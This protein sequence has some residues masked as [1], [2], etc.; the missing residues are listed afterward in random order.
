M[1][2]PTFT[3]KTDL[4]DI[5]YAADVNDLQNEVAPTASASAN[6]R[7]STSYTSTGNVVLTD[8]SMPVQSINFSSNS[9]ITLPAISTANHPFYLV[10]RSTA[11]IVS[12]IFSGSTLS[13]INPGYM[14]TL[15]SD[16]TASWKINSVAA[17]TTTVAG[18]VELATDA[19][20]ITGTDTA[21]AIT[22]ANLRAVLATA[23]NGTVFNLKLS[24]TVSSN[25]LVV[26]LKTHAGTDPSAT[27]PGYV[28]ING[29]VRS[30]T[31]ATSFT[32]ADGT[33]WFGSGAAELGTLEIDYFAYLVW[34]SN[35]SVVAISAARISHG[36]TVNATDF[37]TTTT[38][39]RYLV[40][41]SNFT[42][43]DD[44][45]NIG[46][47]AATLSLTGTGHLWTVPTYTNKN[48][49]QVPIY[50]SRKMSWTPTV[51]SGGGTPTTV[52]KN[53]FYKVKRGQIEYYPD[54]TVVA[55]GTATGNMVLT[56]PFSPT[57]FSTGTGRE[58]SATGKSLSIAVTVGGFVFIS[59]Y[60][61]TTVWVD[62]HQALGIVIGFTE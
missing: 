50:E 52:T 34:D 4:A 60:D 46:R 15:Y 17:A 39:E 31:A 37:S 10:N 44:V 62:G 1:P 8:A 26:A 33:S 20:S 18:I 40:N 6:V 3:N 49:I 5:I 23:I 55:K 57:T 47:F 11:S 24:V 36:T 2:L 28:K 12:V 43:G 53:C 30:V 29:T 38:N 25:D 45:V 35:S 56:Y 9:S 27:D 19:E 54:I 48:L 59:F 16:S 14:A 21:R 32:L 7:Y 42:V 22:P 41:Y 58:V 13:T 51:T 61:A